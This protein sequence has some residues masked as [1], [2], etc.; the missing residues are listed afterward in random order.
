MMARMVSGLET[1]RALTRGPV[2]HTTLSFS[3]AIAQ[4]D[5]SSTS[6]S[7]ADFNNLISALQSNMASI[8]QISLHARGGRQV[9]VAAIGR[10]WGAILGT[11]TQ[12]PVDLAAGENPAADQNKL[13]SEVRGLVASQRRA[14]VKFNLQPPTSIAA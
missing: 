1:S 5:Q 12:L 9:N 13:G 2:F 4:L 3:N 8:A 10:A 7:A 14:G 6:S 11:L